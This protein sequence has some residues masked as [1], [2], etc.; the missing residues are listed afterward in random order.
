M[1]CAV[2]APKA[3]TG[4]VFLT[5]PGLSVK[6]VTPIMAAVAAQQHAFLENGYTLVLLDVRTNVPEGYSIREMA[7]DTAAVMRALGITRADVFGASMGGMRAAELAI[8]HPELVDHLIL[9]ST[10]LRH[11]E[12]SDRQFRHWIDLARKKDE[13]GLLSA[14]GRAIYSPAAWAAN[15][16]AFLNASSPVTDEE[17]TRFIRTASALFGMDALDRVTGISAGTL[18][19]AS[20][21]DKVFTA[22]PSEEIVRALGCESY[23]YGEEY[24]HGVYDEAPDYAQRLFDFCRR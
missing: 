22:G 3:G 21:G 18:V 9:G 16:E 6:P 10:S 19:I 11:A 7:E 17:Y 8:A 14:C 4:K 23:F 12:G 5:L 1:S 2:A 20:R 15:G 13:R 24:G